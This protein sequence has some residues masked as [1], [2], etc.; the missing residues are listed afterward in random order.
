MIKWGRNGHFLACSGYPECRN[1]KEY[2]TRADGTLEIVPSTRPTDQLCPVCGSPMVIR[3]GRFG[4]FQACSRYPECKTTSPLSLGVACPKPDCG[5]YLTEKRSKRGK[6][7]FGCSNYSRTKC[8]FVSWDRPIAQVCPKCAAP[9]LVKKV[10]KA[11][12]RIRCIKPEC[13]YSADEEQ[14]EPGAASA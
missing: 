3:R 5:G 6:V 4:E 8:D 2:T 13:D 14:P 12:N 1:T 9:F 10:S 11:G 7:F